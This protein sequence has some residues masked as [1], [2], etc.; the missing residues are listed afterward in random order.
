MKRGQ[1]G[2]DINAKKKRENKKAMIK[3]NE[4]RKRKL[5]LSLISSKVISRLQRLLWK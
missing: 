4:K 5:A 2:Y 3:K 1:R